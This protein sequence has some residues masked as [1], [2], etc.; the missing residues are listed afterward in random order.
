M[1]ICC[2]NLA[3]YAQGRVGNHSAARRFERR[4]RDCH[5]GRAPLC[6]HGAPPARR[7]AR[8]QRTALRA[9]PAARNTD[10][11]PS[12]SSCR[13]AR[14]VRGTRQIPG[15]CS[16]PLRC[17]PGTRCWLGWLVWC[18]W[19]ACSVLF[20]SGNGSSPRTGGASP[21]GEVKTTV[22]SGRRAP[23]GSEGARP[24]AGN[25]KPIAT[26][27]GHPRAPLAFQTLHPR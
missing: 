22:E 9:A 5:A 6:Q 3:R 23:T 26:T 1:W 27:T 15:G 20:C 8:K 7:T 25:R 11:R 24:M 13:R 2:T 14:S 12:G 16:A 17:N 21:R 4:S 10:P 18:P 19:P